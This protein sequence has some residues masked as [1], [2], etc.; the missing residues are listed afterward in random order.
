[1]RSSYYI[2][3]FVLSFVV[4]SVSASCICSNHPTR[5]IYNCDDDTKQPF[6]S[7][8]YDGLDSHC[9][10]EVKG[11]HVK[12]GW[13]AGLY[14][15]KDMNY[16]RVVYIKEDAEV[17]GQANCAKSRLT[18]PVNIEASCHP[19]DHNLLNP[20][21]PA[22]TT[23]TPTPTTSTPTPTTSTPA[24]TTPTP[25]TPQTTMGT[26][27]T[28]KPSTICNSIDM[29]N[30]L[31]L[32]TSANH[33]NA[34]FCAGS[35]THSGSDALLLAHCNPRSAHPRRWK[36]GVKVIDNCSTLNQGDP[37]G[38]FI[39]GRPIGEF[40]AF[41]KCKANSFEIIYQT[42]GDHAK[43]WDSKDPQLKLSINALFTVIL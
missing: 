21:T 20:T 23:S 41:W 36:A 6:S 3:V 16:Q 5:F 30:H 1:M 14:V 18:G 42:C 39:N 17:V 11:L 7:L 38:L 29:L 32:Q 40:A 27:P 13:K 12:P 19:E 31:I 22:P 34:K 8:Q 10:V 15:L 9:L 35:N 28:M 24:P 2:S 25:T 26:V 37:I 43:V 33:P 4:S